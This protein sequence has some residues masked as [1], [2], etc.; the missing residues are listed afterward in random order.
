MYKCSESVIN[1]FASNGF[2]LVEH[3][4]YVYRFEAVCTGEIA[5][6][7]FTK[8]VQYWNVELVNYTPYV[9]MVKIIYDTLCYLEAGNIIKVIENE[10]KGCV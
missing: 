9:F 10:F 4:E 3:D 8:R 1:A 2:K 5:E 7:I 6:I